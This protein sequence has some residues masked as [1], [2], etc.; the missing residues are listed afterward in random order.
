MSELVMHSVTEPETTRD[1]P[2]NADP[3]YRYLY[4]IF[5]SFSN[6]IFFSL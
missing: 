2:F 1:H 3:S 5:I 6:D 4:L